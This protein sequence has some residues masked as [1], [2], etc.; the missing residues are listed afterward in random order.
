MS[1]EEL[2]ALECVA[3]FRSTFRLSSYSLQYSIVEFEKPV[4]LIYIYNS[5]E[6]FAKQ[7]ASLSAVG[8]F[9]KTKAAEYGE[10]VLKIIR[11]YCEEHSIE[12]N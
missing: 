8:G 12:L 9:G 5:V 6:D 2:L 3:N 4:Y 11:N 1:L 7:V 10:A